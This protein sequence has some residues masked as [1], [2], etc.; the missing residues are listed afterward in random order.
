MHIVA[1]CYLYGMCYNWLYMKNEKIS[2]A[3]KLYWANKSPEEKTKIFSDLAYL[4]HSKT[5]KRKKS[6]HGKYMVACRIKKQ[7]LLNP[8]GNTK[9]T[10]SYKKI[11]KRIK[12][13]LKEIFGVSQ[14]QFKR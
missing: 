2:I 5:S 7:A 6:N 12:A 9:K 11:S 8:L 3:R 1:Y 4:K 14:L 13:E 10:K